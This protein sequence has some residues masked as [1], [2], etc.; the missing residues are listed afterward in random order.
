MKRKITK[1]LLITFLLSNLIFGS[2]AFAY[3][4][5]ESDPNDSLAQADQIGINRWM[6]GKISARE[7]V[8][9]YKFSGNGQK[10]TIGV[11]NTPPGTTYGLVIM[12]KNQNI[13]ARSDNN[14]MSQ[15]IYLDSDWYTDY[16]AVVYSTDGIVSP[17]YT[18]TISV[19]N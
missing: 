1:V 11:H 2:F 13:I 16:Y 17:Y 7:D 19:G 10:L 14:S 9:C 3:S 8:D 15:W 4:T 5:E 12:D 18:Y 6:E